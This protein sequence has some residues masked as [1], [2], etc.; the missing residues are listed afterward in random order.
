MC[1][2]AGLFSL[3]RQFGKSELEKMINSLAHRGPNGQQ[4]WCNADGSVQFAHRR[5]A[6][7]DL[8]PDAAQPM[9]F[10]ERFTIVHN[11]EIYNYLELREEL[12]NK[13]YQFKTKSDT[14]VVLAAFDCWGED[15]VEH[16]EGMF[17]FAIWD[18]KEKTLFTA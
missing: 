17:S 9:H 18:E 12:S 5:L 16:F 2:I 1:G 11:G 4:T 8:S 15:C 13:R 3:N 7:I 6:V 14:E 10:N